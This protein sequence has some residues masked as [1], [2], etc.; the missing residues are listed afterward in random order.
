MAICINFIYHYSYR[1]IQLSAMVS[2]MSSQHKPL[3]TL[4]DTVD[5]QLS[6]ILTQ[7]QRIK[8]LNDQFKQLLKQ[9]NWRH[10]NSQHY[11]A[12]MEKHGCLII[13]ADSASYA[14]K[15]RYQSEIL[16]SQWQ[17]QF[18]LK[19]SSIKLI[20][21]P[22]DQQSPSQATSPPALT[23]S[24]KNIGLLETV[25]KHSKDSALRNSLKT[26]VK[27]AKECQSDTTIK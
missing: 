9:A 3:K 17:Q 12:V 16:L 10:I 21:Q 13:A 8:Q 22:P 1:L 4:L 2:N 27:S 25:A 26:L 20:V 24:A 6:V 19:L 14:T 15:L 7:V 18:D 11:R 5:S 23:I